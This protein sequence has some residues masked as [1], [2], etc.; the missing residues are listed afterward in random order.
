MVTWRAKYSVPGSIGCLSCGFFDRI[1]K[2]ACKHLR[3]LAA[4]LVGQVQHHDDRQ[5]KALPQVRKNRQQRFD[6]PGDAPTTTAVDL[7]QANERFRL[8]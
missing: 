1:D 5:A 4:A 6:T 2:R 7:P 8:S 3:Q